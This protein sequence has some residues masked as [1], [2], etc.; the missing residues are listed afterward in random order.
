[1][2]ALVGKSGSGKSTLAALIPRFYDIRRGAITLDGVDIR[3]YRLQNLR[4][5]IALVSQNLVLFND[6]IRNNIAYGSMQGHGDEAILQAARMAHALEFI[7][8]QQEGLDTTIGD[9][10]L[11]L[12]GGQ[13]QRIA[14]A[15]AF[16]KN[17]PVLILDEA[18]SALDN[19]S[20]QYI[21]SA[22]EQI[23]VNRTT[24]VIAHRL[25]TIERANTILVMDQGAVIEQGSHRELIAKE[26][27]FY[28]KLYLS[29]RE[30][31]L[32]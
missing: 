3:E 15:R 12:S 9:N 19:Q 28:R 14:I 18:T 31:F 5:Q 16:L 25:S 17:A 10:G 32:A 11:Q 22:L 20:E 8:Q 4:T 1:M 7:E 6:T 24:I 26:N 29:S 21:Q 13:R 23:M 27:G 2:V 30:G